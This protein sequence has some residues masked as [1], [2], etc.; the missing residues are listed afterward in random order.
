[1]ELNSECLPSQT[2]PCHP[3]RALARACS[4]RPAQNEIVGTALRHPVEKRHGRKGTIC[5]QFSKL[6]PLL[7]CSEYWGGRLIIATAKG[8]MILRNEHVLDGSAVF[9]VCPSRIEPKTQTFFPNA[10]RLLQRLRRQDLAALAHA[11]P[12]LLFKVDWV[13]GIHVAVRISLR[14]EPGAS[15]Q[16]PAV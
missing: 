10:T 14:P 9:R 15:M 3:C 8:T 6:W 5:G 2:G 12:V 11:R 13:C 4:Q 16:H 7:G 1:M